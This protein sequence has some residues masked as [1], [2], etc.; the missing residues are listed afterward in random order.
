VSHWRDARLQRALESAPDARLLPDIATRRAVLEAARQAVAPAPRARWWKRLWPAA[1]TGLMPW[2]AALATVALATL[3]TVIWRE[4]EIPSARTDTASR[5]RAATVPDVPS[6][7]PVASATPSPGGSASPAPPVPVVIAP[8]KTVPAVP[9]HRPPARA[10]VEP[11]PAAAPREHRAHRAVDDLRD[12]ALAKSGPQRAEEAR[13]AEGSSTARPATPTAPAVAA[14]APAAAPPAGDAR[15]Q[16]PLSQ[17]GGQQPAV[18]TEQRS[19]AEAS[20]RPPPSPPQAASLAARDSAIFESWT[21]VRITGGGRSIE[22]AREQASALPELLSRFERHVQTQDPFEGPVTARIELKQQGGLADLIELGG[23]QLR[24]TRWRA[25]R[26]TTS[27]QRPEPA[28]LQALQTE[29]D[30]LLA[31]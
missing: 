17:A 9:A 12:Q 19:R 11:A 6:P 8:P 28:E 1:G 26:P 2:N 4:Q 31:R 5:D 21:H 14:P 20:A 18:Q 7:A 15:S 10:Q 24:W 23:K 16:G 29:V 25:G 22:L 13:Q 30:R 27:T 3:V